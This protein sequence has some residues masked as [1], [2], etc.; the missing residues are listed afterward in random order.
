[1]K[2]EG[3]IATTVKLQEYLYDDLK[4]L[5][6]RHK[7]TLQSF[8]EKCIYLYVHENQFR[9]SVN[10]FNMPVLGMTGSL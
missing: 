6:V 4:V 7:F 9:D 8:V 2:N 10:N 1:M 5:G 3:K